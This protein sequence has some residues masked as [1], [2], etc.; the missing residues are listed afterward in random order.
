MKFSKLFTKFS[1]LFVLLFLAFSLKGQT[2][3]KP[4][5]LADGWQM[6]D[7]SKISQ[8][9]EEISKV[10][11]QTAGWYKATVPGTILT[12]LVNNGVYPEPLWG[13]NNRPDK[14]P[15]TLCRTPYWYRI[16]F[17]VPA[18]YKGKKIWLNFDGINYSAKVFLNS[19]EVG[20]IKGAFIRGLFDISSYVTA[21]QPAA[22][23]VLIS[24]QPNPGASHEHTIALGM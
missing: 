19:K 16:I 6:Q 22:L 10:G 15:E 23:A 11:F 21:G 12:T 7:A 24:P 9:G 17:K 14:I 20:N 4:F 13:E 18:D 2:N 8:T 3:S 5:I 1:T